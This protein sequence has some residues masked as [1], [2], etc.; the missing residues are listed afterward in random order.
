MLSSGR[1]TFLRI[2]PE[3]TFSTENIRD[4]N[5]EERR[6]KFP[7]EVK[8]KRMKRY[9]YINCMAECRSK[10]VFER[11]GC[12]PLTTP[13]SGPYP[14]CNSLDQISCVADSRG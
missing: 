6:C 11:C 4:L 10:I 2:T 5:Y 12:V 9:S 7:N 14:I 3:K 13:N 8:L 1:E